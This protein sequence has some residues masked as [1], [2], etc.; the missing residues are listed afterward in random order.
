MICIVINQ[1]I[2]VMWLSNGA[3]LKSTDNTG[4]FL[5]LLYWIKIIESI[6]IVTYHLALTHSFVKICSAVSNKTTLLEITLSNNAV[7]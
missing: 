7:G 2:K 1:L 6:V 3:A 4:E 5:I